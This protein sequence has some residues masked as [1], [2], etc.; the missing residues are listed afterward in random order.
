MERRRVGNVDVIALIDNVRTYP[1]AVVYPQA[2]DA[3]ARFAGYMDSDGGIALNFA[4]FVVRDGATTVLVDTGW[5]PELNGRLLAELA[6]ASVSPDD[7]DI[8]TFTHLHG[9]HTGWNIDRATGRQ[10]FSRARYL[11]P[12]GDWD[13]Y[14]ATTPPQD[15]FT[16]DMLPLQAAAR[17]ELIDGEYILS[18]AVT[19]LPTPGHTPGHTSF[20]IT[21]GSEHGC[22]LGDVV[23]SMIDAEMPSLQTAF[24]ADHTMARATRVATIARL[25]AN[26]ALVGASHLAV[27]GFGRL[28]VEGGSSRWIPD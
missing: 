22:I 9:D 18:S 7:I 13:H 23:I 12:R 10:L 15:S 20:M 24:D 14:A 16:R 21:S 5:G 28:S 1:A 8:V 19:S 4:A 25:A 2:G 27:P 26:K 17:V 6:E 3:L 11:V